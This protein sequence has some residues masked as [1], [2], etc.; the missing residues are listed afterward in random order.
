GG[1]AA[2]AAVLGVAHGGAQEHAVG[3]DLCGTLDLRRHL[4]RGVV[5]LRHLPFEVDEV[6]L[7]VL[8]E[9]DDVD[10]YTGVGLD[11]GGDLPD[12]RARVGYVEPGL[13]HDL[14]VDAH[15]A[16]E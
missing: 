10:D 7:P 11:T 16:V 4:G 12:G 15:H 8:L 9:E 13:R 5:G 6:G 14:G 2:T 3:P 1:G